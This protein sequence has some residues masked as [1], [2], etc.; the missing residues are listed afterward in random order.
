MWRG[1]EGTS[2][3]NFPMLWLC[4]ALSLLMELYHKMPP[5]LQSLPHLSPWAVISKLHLFCTWFTPQLLPFPHFVLA[6]L[7]L[8]VSYLRKAGTHLTHLICLLLGV[9]P[10]IT[11][12]LNNNRLN[13]IEINQASHIEPKKNMDIP[14]IKRMSWVSTG[15]YFLGIARFDHQWTF[16]PHCHQWVCSGP[17]KIVSSQ[18]SHKNIP[19]LQC[20]DSKLPS[21]KKHTRYHSAEQL[22]Y[23]SHQRYGSPSTQIEF[24]QVRNPRRSRNS[25]WPAQGITWW[26]VLVGHR[27]LQTSQGQLSES[28]S[29]WEFL[30]LIKQ[31]Q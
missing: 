28:L 31:V 1:D 4:L 18:I 11:G 29:S 12:G 17:I 9:Q 23:S 25:V 22:P 5:L 6:S 19:H 3:A 20:G 10:P 21:W 26:A 13:W 8:A 15:K 2:K 30:I 27:E 24:L 7:P 16:A 14:R